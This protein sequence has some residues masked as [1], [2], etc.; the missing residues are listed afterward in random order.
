MQSRVKRWLYRYYGITFILMGL[1]FLLFGL[2]SLNLIY[3][4][5]S[6]IE[7]I[8]DY[9]IM[10]LQD[11]GLLQMLGLLG[12]GYL[13]LAFYLLFKACEHILVMRMTEPD[14]AGNTVAENKQ[15][16]NEL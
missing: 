3:L 16:D 12:Y 6:N 4:L 15:I 2:L 5:K 10:G 14:K 13:G 8:L 7:L 1:S 9:G 11:G